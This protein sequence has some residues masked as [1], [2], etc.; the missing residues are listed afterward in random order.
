MTET[1]SIHADYLRLVLSVVS[2]AQALIRDLD[3]GKQVLADLA[4]SAT[5]A[6]SAVLLSEGI[7][8]QENLLALRSEVGALAAWSSDE[9][10]S[11]R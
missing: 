3:E 9:I 1:V 8:S 2:A 6:R 10:G 5:L 11:D 7:R 4:P